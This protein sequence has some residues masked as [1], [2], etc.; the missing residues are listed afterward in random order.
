MN[1]ANIIIDRVCEDTGVTKNLL[2]SNRRKQFIVD[3]KQI[4]VFALSE[5]G[6][7]QQYIG[8]VL[9][10][11]DHTTV[12]YLKNKK[13]RHSL[14]NRLRANLVVKSYLDMAL[15]ENACLRENLG[16]KI[17]EEGS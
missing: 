5:L 12:N 16:V 17:S 14:R 11:A 3:A 8:N 1:I 15:L 10:Y 9:N 7:T 6:F 13:C 2:M 4:V